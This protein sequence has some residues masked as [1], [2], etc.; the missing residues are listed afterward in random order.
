MMGSKRCA[1]FEAGCALEY[2]TTLAWQQPL[3]GRPASLLPVMVSNVRFLFQPSI[4]TWMASGP[5]R[6]SESFRSA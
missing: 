2:W 6:H 4:Y 1:L 3:S 5:L